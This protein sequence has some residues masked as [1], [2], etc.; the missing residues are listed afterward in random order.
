MNGIRG[1]IIALGALAILS[2]ADIAAQDIESIMRAR[3]RLE[4]TEGQLQSL[5]A[6]RRATVQERATEMA[7]MQELRSQL[8]AGQIQRSQVMAF[9]EERAET[10]QATAEQRRGQLEA[11]LDE[12]QL[13]MVR[14]MRRRGGRMGV[15]PGGRPGT[16]GP[17]FAPRG[18]AGFDG[19][20]RPFR[21]PPRTSLRN[22]D[23][24][25]FGGPPFAGQRRRG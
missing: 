1:G 14:E 16:D 20:Q 13:E 21:G 25:G 7:E 6:I 22:Q 2:A 23:R 3:E 24:R 10:R 17:G 18:R 9:M 19:P 8:D 4:L 11:V 12:S 15:R 5:E